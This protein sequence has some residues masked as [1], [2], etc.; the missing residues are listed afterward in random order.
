MGRSLLGRVMRAIPAA[1]AAVPAVVLA[2]AH[3]VWACGSALGAGLWPPDEVTL[4]EAVVTRNYGEVSR[5]IGIGS[6]PNQIDAVRAQLIGTDAGRRM[7]AIEAAVSIPDPAMV[8]LLLASG[9]R[10]DAATIARL[11]CLLDEKPN[12]EITE[13]LMGLGDEPWPPCELAP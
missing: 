12:A 4:P 7:T 13:L 6:D 2:I 10:P 1:I 9:A 3:L 11:R 5:L 8:R